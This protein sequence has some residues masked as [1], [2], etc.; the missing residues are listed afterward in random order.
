VEKKK[1]EEAA[2]DKTTPHRGRPSI[3]AAQTVTGDFVATPAGGTVG[4]KLCFTGL[5][6]KNSFLS[7]KSDRGGV[8]KTIYPEA[9]D[10]G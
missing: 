7:R 5:K 8:V 1:K 4:E 3:C 6:I 10:R 9:G 2:R